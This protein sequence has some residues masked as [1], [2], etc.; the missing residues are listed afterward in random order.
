VEEATELEESIEGID[1]ILWMTVLN[2]PIKFYLKSGIIKSLNVQ[3]N[4]GLSV[5]SWKV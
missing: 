1:D 4:E 2:K 3:L 5:N